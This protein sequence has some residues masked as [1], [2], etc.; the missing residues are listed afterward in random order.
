MVSCFHVED[1]FVEVRGGLI[2]TVYVLNVGHI[3]GLANA[4]LRIDTGGWSVNRSALLKEALIDCS[5]ENYYTLCIT[6]IAI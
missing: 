6:K 2:T 3:S 5:L 1:S 4:P